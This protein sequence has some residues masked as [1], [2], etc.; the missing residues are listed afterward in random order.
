M[1]RYFRPCPPQVHARVVG[2]L[3]IAVL[4]WTPYCTDTVNTGILEKEGKKN[5]NFFLSF[6]INLHSCQVNKVL[7]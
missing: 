6:H 4:V 5:S 3:H 1:L 2:G 7:A